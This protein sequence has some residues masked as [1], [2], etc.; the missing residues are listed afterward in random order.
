MN[1]EYKKSINTI[2]NYKGGLIEALEK[3]ISTLS[4]KQDEVYKEEGLSTNSRILTARI[5][6]MQESLQLIK[7]T[8]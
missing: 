5:F 3:K 8:T 7:E 4:D 1:K 6:G 2:K